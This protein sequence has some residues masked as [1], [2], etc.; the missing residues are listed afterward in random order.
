M[1]NFPEIVAHIDGGSRGNP[2]PAAYGVAFE[3]TQGKPVASFGKYIG[4]T[5]NN[6]A[7]YNGLLAA[8][9][10]ALNNNHLR[11][12]VL[13]DSEL[14]TKQILGQYKV[15]SADLKP[16]VDRAKNLMTRF[17]SFSIRHVYREENREADRLANEAMDDAA[18]G[19]PPRPA[20][21]ASKPAPA[22]P[23]V[24]APAAAVRTEA[25][26]ERGTLRPHQQLNLF[27]G[28]E[29]ELEIRRKK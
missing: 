4:R 14:M 7:E 28:E 1:S 8:L 27:E 11:L 26:Y 17:E 25:T 23:P 5:T 21:V 12:R 24:A 13:T 22:P 15:K 16:L 9:E 10:Y 18:S 20:V 3:T 19:R 29:V 2:G 6:V